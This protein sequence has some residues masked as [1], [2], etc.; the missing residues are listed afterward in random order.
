MPGQ[1]SQRDSGLDQWRIYADVELFQERLG[2]YVDELAS[3]GNGQELEL[4]ARAGNPA[5][6]WYLKGGRFYLPFGLRLQDNTSFVRGVTGINMT[7]PDEGF[8]LGFER[9]NWSAQIDV[10]KNVGGPNARL[11]DQVIGQF[12]WVQPTW[13]AGAATSFVKADL[14]NRRTIGLFAGARTG[15]VSWLGEADLVR[16]EGY[17]QGTRSLVSMLGEANWSFYKGNNLKLTGEFFDPDRKVPEDAQ[18]RWSLL[19]ELTPVPF[20]QL[21]AGVR[22]YDGIPQSP[23]QNRKVSFVELHAF[24]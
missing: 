19:Y 1:P 16:D 7:T 14:G 21:R 13:R 6:G 24:L 5:N 12:V 2:F 3:P 23:F 10:T 11:G 15:K 22:N 20:I 4:Y 17:P 8:E 18:T 9:S